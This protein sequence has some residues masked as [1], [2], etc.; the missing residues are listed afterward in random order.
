MKVAEVGERD[1][2]VS[3]EVETQF[4][5]QVEHLAIEYRVHWGR[6]YFRYDVV[7]VPGIAEKN[8]FQCDN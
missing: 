6:R 5:A 4:G 2:A 3:G 8:S 7:E 1:V